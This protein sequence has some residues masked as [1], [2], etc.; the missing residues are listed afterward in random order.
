MNEPSKWIS[1][2]RYFHV[3]LFYSFPFPL[4]VREIDVTAEGRSSV[5]V[6]WRFNRTTQSNMLWDRELCL[7]KN[8]HLWDN[9]VWT[10]LS[11]DIVWSVCALGL[12]KHFKLAKGCGWTM[13]VQVPSD[14]P[15]CYPIDF[16]YNWII[17]EKTRLRLR[18]KTVILLRIFIM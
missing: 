12:L 16:Q 3:N 6:T 9:V 4:H 14:W 7:L 1:P 10:R 18:V 13:H 8:N 17:E 11:Q 15:K 5:L 2:F